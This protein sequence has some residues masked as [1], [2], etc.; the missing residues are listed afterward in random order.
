MHISKLYSSRKV[1]SEN[2]F[3]AQLQQHLT[4]IHYSLSLES[5][6]KL[7]SVFL[8]VSDSGCSV[9]GMSQGFLLDFGN[10]QYY[11]LWLTGE[12]VGGKKTVNEEK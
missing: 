4:H 5:N 3:S 2:D 8:Y 1:S 12:N 11:L 6:L 9:A 10:R 7:K